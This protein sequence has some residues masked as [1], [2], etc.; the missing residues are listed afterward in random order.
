MAEQERGQD[1]GNGITVVDWD[2]RAE[3]LAE[4]GLLVNTTSLG[5]TGQGPLDLDLTHLPPS[6]LVSDVVYTPLETEL[7]A[8]AR[9]RG[10]PVVDGLGMLLYQ[11]QTGFEAWFGLRPEVTQGLRDFVLDG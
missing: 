6:A 9:S 11:A 10:N 5:M 1:L 2:R 4:A 7:L 3:A 8:R